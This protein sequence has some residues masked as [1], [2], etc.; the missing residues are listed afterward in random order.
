MERAI[1]GLENDRNKANWNVTV[2]MA[3]RSAGSIRQCHVFC[4]FCFDFFFVA[5]TFSSLPV[6]GSVFL[7]DRTG[8][9]RVLVG[10]SWVFLDWRRLAF[11]R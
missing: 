4:C 7:P 11:L 8:F 10:S 5:I 9:S 6:V 2:P 1:V 3:R